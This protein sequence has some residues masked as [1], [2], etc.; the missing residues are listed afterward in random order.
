M[1]WPWWLIAG[2]LVVGANVVIMAVYVAIKKIGAYL[3]R[4]DPPF[5]G[6][7]Y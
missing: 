5:P 1:S 3:T 4:N 2:A 7:A 6:G